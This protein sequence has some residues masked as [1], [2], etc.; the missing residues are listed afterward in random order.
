MGVYLRHMLL[1]YSEYGTMLV[2]YCGP[3]SQRSR[4]S[5]GQGSPTGSVRAVL[6]STGVDPAPPSGWAPSGLSDR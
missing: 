5:R 6:G 4:G 2:D 1:G 3:V